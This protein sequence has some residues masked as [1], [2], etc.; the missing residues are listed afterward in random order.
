[1]FFKRKGKKGSP[2]L[3]DDGF[4]YA[5]EGEQYDSDEF[6][7]DSDY[8]HDSDA[9]ADADTDSDD[10]SISGEENGNDKDGSGGNCNAIESREG[11]Q[12]VMC[13]KGEDVTVTEAE[14]ADPDSGI[15]TE[16]HCNKETDLEDEE[17]VKWPSS[18]DDSY[19]QISKPNVT[20]S[21]NLHVDV[22]GGQL[23]MEVGVD[24]EEDDEKECSQTEELESINLNES[25]QK[26]SILDTDA[27]SEHEPIPSSLDD[28]RSLLAL[29][30]E[31]DR[32]DILKAILQSGTNGENTAL[33]QLL[34]NNVLVQGNNEFTEDDL[35]EVFLPPLHIAIASSS[36]NAAS[37]FLRMGS[38][39]A[40]RTKI[41]G[42]WD[43]PGWKDE[44][45][46]QMYT[47]EK[48]G[49]LGNKSA[50][51][52][53]FGSKQS[54]ESERSEKVEKK[55]WFGFSKSP[56]KKATGQE[57][58][59]E[60]EPAKL[61]GIKH[62]FTAEALRAIGSDEVERLADLSNSGF[63]SNEL[64]E[65]G[66]KDLF[67]WCREMNA[68]K[69]AKMLE[70]AY[71]VKV[72]VALKEDGKKEANGNE[73]IKQESNG[74]VKQQANV[75]ETEEDDGFIYDV[76]T[77]L[78]IRSK[79]ETNEFLA[80][81]L[82][83]TLDDIAE[84][85]S[86]TQGLLLQRGD[87]TNNALLSQVRMLKKNRADIE[88]ETS[89]WQNKVAD[90]IAELDMVMIWWQKKGGVA[91][92]IPDVVHRRSEATKMGQDI[93]TLTKQEL[94]VVIKEA[95][96]CADLSEM[97]VKRIRAS[98]KDLKKENDRNIERVEELGLSGAVRLT[99]KLKEEV[100]ERKEELDSVIKKEAD[101]TAKVQIV[102]ELLEKDDV[103]RNATENEES[104]QQSS[105]ESSRNT[106]VVERVVEVEHL[107][108][109]VIESIQPE[110]PVFESMDGPRQES[111]IRSDEESYDG[112]EDEDYYD[113]GDD[114]SYD[115]C[116][117]DYDS[118][119]SADELPHSETIKQG[120]STALVSWIEDEDLGIF[121]FKMWDL[122]Q[123]I[124]GLSKRAIKQTAKNT[125]E[126]V[127]NLPR[128]MII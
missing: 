61:E 77:L 8:S 97:K 7:T 73:N 43:G 24:D 78:Q 89:L 106:T 22:R 85:V 105:T 124:F 6:E 90:R 37:C 49:A 104:T 96:K 25:P 27:C 121:A 122:V 46:E 87:P 36:A 20:T 94:K 54:P 23:E 101:L 26:M 115:S 44:K 98:I 28:N 4:Y 117:D 62:A 109:D 2:K 48:W 86:V 80:S 69:C 55:G 35:E 127:V 88:D 118:Y 113:D 102:R 108:E 38:N 3:D 19:E 103:A 16:K 114:D 84:E 51:E 83:V 81:E 47:A 112:D 66:G 116:D 100:K 119:D 32:V 17:L 57:S 12:L 29:A 126:D 59:I 70:T 39:P 21:K 107:P 92:D 75:T 95:T 123:R 72:P 1:M 68:S 18:S 9:D 120:K 79:L 128:V 15:G 30:A 99:R 76:S 64:I 56:S 13:N 42:N 41:P 40:I 82:S 110:T 50:W 10:E 93:E 71:A 53:A 74:Q 67:S 52:L 14:E 45:G 63:G 111:D 34:L 91:S 60:I 33:V 125:V 5:E 11:K 58:F 65:I 31:H